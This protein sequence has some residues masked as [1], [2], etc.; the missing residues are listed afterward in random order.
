MSVLDFLPPTGDRK[1]YRLQASIGL[2]EAA[3]LEKYLVAEDLPFQGDMSCLIRT[4]LTYGLVKLGQEV[5]SK[6]DTF[7]QSIKHVSGSELLRWSTS[8]CDN[9]AAAS[10]DHLTL[11][12]ESG[13]VYRAED[14][15]SQVTEV[16]QSIKNA[17]ARNMVLHHL[18]KRG[19]IKAAVRL[20]EALMHEDIN[21]YKFDSLFAEVFN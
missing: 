19:F 8:Y 17:A 9:F 4:L 20:R 7:I 13:D 2:K 5:N 14:V 18:E 12:L 10:V 16:V 6:D 3:E 15:F 1:G 21:V 11:A